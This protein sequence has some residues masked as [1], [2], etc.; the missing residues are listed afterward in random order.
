MHLV[1]FTDGASRGNPGPASFG[2]VIK[3]KDGLI[4][5]QEGKAIG[6]QTNNFAEYTALLSALTYIEKYLIKDTPIKVECFLDSLLVVSQLNG[7]YKI[8][9]S[10]LF[11]LN[12]GIK[13]ISKRLGRVSFTHVRRYKNILADKL[14]N[15]ALDNS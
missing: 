1:V 11:S 5:H 6:P 13:D 12:S 2:F 8:R 3:T 15:I 14:A 10:A 4:L 9:N 7:V